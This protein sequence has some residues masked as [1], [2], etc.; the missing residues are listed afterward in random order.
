MFTG[1]GNS[2]NSANSANSVNSVNSVNSNN[3]RLGEMIN[4]NTQAGII[5]AAGSK[6]KLI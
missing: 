3:T 5:A 6:P 1:K 4:R 2:T